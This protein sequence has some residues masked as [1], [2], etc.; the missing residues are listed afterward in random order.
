[1]CIIHNSGGRSSRCLFAY[2]NRNKRLSKIFGNNIRRRRMGY[3][4]ETACCISHRNWFISPIYAERLDIDFDIIAYCWA[5]DLWTHLFTIQNDPRQGTTYVSIST[6]HV[7]CLWCLNETG[8][9]NTTSRRLIYNNCFQMKQ[10]STKYFAAILFQY[11]CSTL[12]IQLG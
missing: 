3:V 7:V 1:M 4:N 2:S 8:Q 12:K 11:F 9:H 6:L 5:N 10:F